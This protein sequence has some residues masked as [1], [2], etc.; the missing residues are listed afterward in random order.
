MVLRL[1]VRQIIEKNA[2]WLKNIRHNEC[3][4]TFKKSQS[5]SQIGL[6]ERFHIVDEFCILTFVT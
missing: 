3:S 1:I 4:R 5:Q 2:H 6:L